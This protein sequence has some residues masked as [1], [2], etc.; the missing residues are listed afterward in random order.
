M[1]AAW[2]NSTKNAAD[3]A[4]QVT[5]G[6]VAYQKKLAYYTCDEDAVES[7]RQALARAEEW[8]A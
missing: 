6:I 4:G 7:L 2:D 8:S 1:N 5:D 3:L